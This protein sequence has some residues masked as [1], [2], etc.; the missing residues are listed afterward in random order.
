MR[1]YQ[2]VLSP[3][4]PTRK[5]KHNTQQRKHNTQQRKHNTQQQIICCKNPDKTQTQDTTTK[6][7]I[8]PE[9]N[10]KYLKTV[11]G[12]VKKSKMQSRCSTPHKNA[13]PPT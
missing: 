7:I 4:Q 12:H 1:N 2:H 9:K 11:L 5:R 6:Q 3:L 10:S 13:Q 8:W